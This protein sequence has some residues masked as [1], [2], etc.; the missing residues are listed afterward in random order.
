MSNRNIVRVVC[1]TL[2]AGVFCSM[3]CVC[4][5]DGKDAI[6]AATKLYDEGRYLDAVEILQSIAA[7]DP[8]LRAQAYYEVAQC[9]VCERMLDD[10]IVSFKLGLQST[11]EASDPALRGK[12]EWG[13]GLAYIAA[14]LWDEA[15]DIIKR[16]ESKDPKD[17]YVLSIRRDIARRDYAKVAAAAAAFDTLYPGQLGSFPFY[18][19]VQ[20]T[21][22]GGP[23]ETAACLTA[24][25]DLACRHPA[26]VAPSWVKEDLVRALASRGRID[27]AA[28][29]LRICAGAAAD[30]NEKINRL[31][32][33]GLVY[34]KARR[35]A[36]AAQ[37][38]QDAFNITGA[39]AEQR[40]RA[41]Y[42]AGCFYREAGQKATAEECL[43]AVLEQ[44]P[45]SQVVKEVRM[46]L[47]MWAKEK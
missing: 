24:V 43:R 7:S 8:A 47:N 15:D 41:K 38:Y 23:D 25:L 36:D 42:D 44:F 28:K 17:G 14:G 29:W 2:C 1:V 10:A 37:A 34:G 33:L 6:S 45:T 46:R 27:D 9:H 13:L 39:P 19:A 5:G 22:S 35:Y 18:L 3:S 16:V 11:T 20:M 31:L 30:D 26:E 12:L 21:T 4:R 40:A 32:R